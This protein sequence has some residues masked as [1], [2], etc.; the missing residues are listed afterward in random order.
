MGQTACCESNS[1]KKNIIEQTDRNGIINGYR[2]DLVTSMNQNNLNQSQNPTSIKGSI[3]ANINEIG[4]VDPLR[5]ANTSNLRASQNDLNRFG[6]ST[7][8]ESVHLNNSTLN[9]NNSVNNKLNLRNSTMPFQCIK[10]FEA[11]ENKI[12]SLI[13]L[14]SGD[15]ATGSYDCTIKIWDI[16]TQICQKNIPETG[17]VLCL[18]EFFP[19]I[20]LCGTD[21]NHIQIYDLNNSNN[22][23]LYSFEGHLLW[24]N[25]LV[26][27]NDTYFA[28]GSNDSDIRIWNYE[29][30]NCVNVLSGHNNCVLT[31]IGLQNGNLC[32]G[33]ADLTI[34]IWDWTNGSCVYTLTGH[35]KIIKCVYQLSNGYI[36]SGSDDKTIRVWNN[37]TTIN[38]L[39]G[40][41]KSIRSL[42]QVS[43]NLFASASFDK[44]IKIW[45]INNMDCVQTLVGH[46]SNVICLLLHSTGVLI[47][48]STDH[49]I[50]IWK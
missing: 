19:G 17:N 21:E 40:H 13:E 14:S 1:N 46:Q 8:T 41:T 20:L 31:M 34:K 37:Y 9:L 50:K 24:I 18:L 43:N 7:I 32:S 5:N 11:H 29:S 22:R 27:C 45:N 30:K 28:S 35:K 6:A 44:T 12:V 4:E 49:T 15:L 47:S 36:I 48:C 25:C 33:S 38:E 39:T 23:A 2:N 16:N 42:C 26:K 3:N 10:T